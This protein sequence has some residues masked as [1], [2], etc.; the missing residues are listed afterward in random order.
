MVKMNGGVVFVSK[1]K[2]KKKKKKGT[3]NNYLT[4]KLVFPL[5]VVHNDDIL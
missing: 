3:K 2:K 5:F 4:K 1:K